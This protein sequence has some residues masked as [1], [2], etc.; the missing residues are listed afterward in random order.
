MKL[1]LINICKL[2]L[3]FDE[4]IRPIFNI[5][6]KITQNITII[7]YLDLTE[8][9]LTE[10]DKI[11]ISGTAL[12]DFDYMQNLDK[13][14]WLKNTSKSVLGICGGGQIIAQIFAGKIKIGQEIGM[15]DLE[16][17]ENDILFGEFIFSQVY[18]L[19]NN[20][21]EIPLGFKLIA[22]TKYPQIIKNESSN[23]YAILFHLEVRCENLIINFLNL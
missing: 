10:F 7:N 2:N 11:I 16:I 13:F 23:I 9:K 4:F 17:I 5:C 1:L 18:C 19:H 22:K 20:Y 3:H 15:K 6:I 8:D 14:Y 12:K 21:F